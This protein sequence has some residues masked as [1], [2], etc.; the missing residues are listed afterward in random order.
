V[1]RKCGLTSSDFIDVLAPTGIKAENVEFEG[2]LLTDRFE[3][4]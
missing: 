4:P 2:Q 3:A 1:L